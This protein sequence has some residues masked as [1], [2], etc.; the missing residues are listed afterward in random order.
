MQ[1]SLQQIPLWNAGENTKDFIRPPVQIVTVPYNASRQWLSQYYLVIGMWSPPADQLNLSLFAVPSIPVNASGA[2]A[3]VALRKRLKTTRAP[4]RTIWGRLT[5]APRRWACF[6][7]YIDLT[8]FH[9]FRT[10]LFEKKGRNW[11]TLTGDQQRTV[12]PGIQTTV[13]RLP[14]PC[15]H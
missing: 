11:I 1:P 3:S 7:Q 12:S 5:L 6:F 9:R 15:I 8:P 4:C 13:S 14:D 10:I 2:N